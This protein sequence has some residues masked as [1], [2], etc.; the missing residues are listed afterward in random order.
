MTE[1]AADRN[2]A[3][4]DDDADEEASRIGD[5]LA[6]HGGP[7]FELQRRLGMLR[8]DACLLVGARLCSSR[9][10]GAFHFC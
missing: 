9:S 10:P 3:E 4:V 1:L 8:E 2:I 6:S 5:Y 7:F